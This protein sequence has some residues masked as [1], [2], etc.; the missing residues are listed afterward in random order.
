MLLTGTFALMPIFLFTKWELSA[1]FKVSCDLQSATRRSFVLKCRLKFIHVA[2]CTNDFAWTALLM[3]ALC[4][5][6]DVLINKCV[7]TLLCKGFRQV[8]SNAV[9]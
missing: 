6:Q 3:V 7:Y 8:L 5:K 2:D 1:C 9:R 4:L